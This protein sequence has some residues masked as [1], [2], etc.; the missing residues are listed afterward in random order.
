MK[1]KTKMHYLGKK[2]GKSQKSGVEYFAVTM[3]DGDDNQYNFYVPNN[4]KSAHVYDAVQTCKK[5]GEYQVMLEIS[6]YQGNARVDLA[7]VAE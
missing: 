2:P 6:S 5:F 1:F 3:M 7:G 4:E